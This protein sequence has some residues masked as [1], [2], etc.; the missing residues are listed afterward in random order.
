MFFAQYQSL[1]DLGPKY[2]GK[3]LTVNQLT[4]IVRRNIKN[5]DVRTLSSRS[6]SIKKNIV[7]VAGIFDPEEMDDKEP[8]IGVILF[9]NPKQKTIKIT[10]KFWKAFAFETAEIY[11]HEMI[12]QYQ[13]VTRLKKN[14]SGCKEF[15]SHA[16]DPKIREDQEYFGNYD[17]IDAYAFGVVASMVVHKRSLDQIPVWLVYQSLFVDEPAILRKLDREINKYLNRLEYQDDQ[18]SVR[19]RKPRARSISRRHNK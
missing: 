10:K 14:I 15:K 18:T 12:H 11:T 4:G 8:C 9:F 5:P 7:S 17:E 13:H 6:P 19:P 1:L 16:V 2:I 3:K